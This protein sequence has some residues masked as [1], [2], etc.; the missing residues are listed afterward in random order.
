MSQSDY[1]LIGS[2]LRPYIKVVVLLL[3]ILILIFLLPALAT[4]LPTTAFRFI[5][6]TTTALHLLSVASL[7]A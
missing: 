1:M 3:P 6:T 5:T 7:A 4:S 2:L